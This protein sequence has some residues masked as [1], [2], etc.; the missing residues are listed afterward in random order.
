MVDAVNPIFNFHCIWSK[1][2][3]MGGSHVVFLLRYAYAN[4]A[5][6]IA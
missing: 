6:E 3:H 1:Y 5:L 2:I 4:S